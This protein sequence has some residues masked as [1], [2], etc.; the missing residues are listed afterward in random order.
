[1]GE[2]NSVGVGETAGDGV[3]NGS[4]ETEAASKIFRE[5]SNVNPHQLL[6]GKTAAAWL[7]S[8]TFIEPR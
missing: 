4:G 2:G 8:G 6:D 1:V 5:A 3:N 7:K